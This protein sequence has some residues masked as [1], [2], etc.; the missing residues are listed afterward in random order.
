MVPLAPGQAAGVV[1]GREV[2]GRVP[3]FLH[4]FLCAFRSWGPGNKLA[5]VRDIASSRARSGSGKP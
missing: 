1:L 4:Y 2:C 3:Y 5:V